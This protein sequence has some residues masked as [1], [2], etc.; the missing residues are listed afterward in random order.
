MLNLIRE[1]VRSSQ[2]NNLQQY[3]FLTMKKNAHPFLTEINFIKAKIVYDADYILNGAVD[4][5]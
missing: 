4:G 5:E 1:I 2:L 3:E